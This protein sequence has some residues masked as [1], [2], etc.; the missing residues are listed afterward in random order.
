MSLMKITKTVWLY[1]LIVSIAILNK[2]YGSHLDDISISGGWSILLV[3]SIIIITILLFNSLIKRR[4]SS[5]KE[6]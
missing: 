5:N 4:T 3:V 1:I 6:S 2:L